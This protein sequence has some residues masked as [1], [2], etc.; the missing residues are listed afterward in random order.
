MTEVKRQAPVGAGSTLIILGSC[1]SA[2]YVTR[3][4]AR[5]PPHTFFGASDRGPALPGSGHRI[6]EFF[7]VLRFAHVLLQFF[8][9][10]DLVHF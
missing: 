3:P 9:R 1:K 7:V 4:I 2:L 6:E 10:F 5:M 8:H